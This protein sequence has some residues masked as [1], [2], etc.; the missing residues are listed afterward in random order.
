MTIWIHRY[1]R[2]YQL[3]LTHGGAQ[4]SSHLYIS[5]PTAQ[6]SLPEKDLKLLLYPWL[7][8]AHVHI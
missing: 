1:I 4:S 6:P 2:V 7:N 5:L 8:T 3:M